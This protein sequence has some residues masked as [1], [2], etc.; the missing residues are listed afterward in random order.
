VYTHIVSLVFYQIKWSHSPS[1][2]SFMVFQTYKTVY[3]QFHLD[4]SICHIVKINCVAL[5]LIKMKL[6]LKVV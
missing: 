6:C 3:T 1:N 4:M 5:H 2:A